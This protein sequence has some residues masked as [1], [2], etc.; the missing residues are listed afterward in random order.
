MTDRERNIK[1][2][3]E[4]DGTNY[5]GWQRQPEHCTIQQ[6]LE[7]AVEA[8][9]QTCTTVHGAGRTDAGVHALAQVANFRTRS[10]ISIE[11]FPLALNAHLPP[12]IAVKHAEEVRLDFHAQFDAKSKLYRYT[13][14]NQQIRSPLLGRYAYRCWPELDVSLMQRAALH[15]LG[16]HDFSAFETESRWERPRVRHV[17]RAEFIAEPPRIDFWI[18]ANGFLYNMVRAIIGTLLLVGWRKLSCDD[19][20]NIIASKDRTFAG[21]TAP[22]QGLC[23]MRVTY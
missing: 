10:R 21:P 2:V 1:I 18:E 5:H 11:R 4:Y 23:L 19:F 14:L 12:D 3:V 8:V 17:T 15:L 22:P 16:E 7:E 20:R 13:L 6:C 9:T